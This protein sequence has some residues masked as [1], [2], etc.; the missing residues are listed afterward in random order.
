[1][2]IS[3]EYIWFGVGLLGQGLFF[4]RSFF[5]WLASE[6]QK[7]CVVPVIFWYFS[8]AGGVILLVYAI[9]RKDP[10]FI[11]GQGMGILVYLRNLYL[12]HSP[13]TVK[14]PDGR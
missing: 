1:M 8:L 9:Y 4:L 5:Q 14:E 2:T 12:I 6:R 10:V 3:A 13:T 11:L 7:A